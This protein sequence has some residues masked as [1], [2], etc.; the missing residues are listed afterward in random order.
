[1]AYHPFRH[2]GLKVLAIALA[3]LLWLTVAGEH[4]VE[5]TLRVPLEFR[6]TPAALEIVGEPPSTV[7]VRLRGSSTTLSRLEPGE[8]VTVLDLSGA[9]PGS[10]LFHLRAD[11]VRAPYGV[12]I[13]QVVPSTL[14]LVLEQSLTR[15][16][17]VVPATEGD[18]APGYVTGSISAEPSTVEVVGPESSVRQLASATTEPVVIQG[19]RGR[20]RDVVTVGVED[21]AV[22]LAQPQRA[23]VVVEI[24][25]APVERD[26]AGV[27]VRWRNLGTGL[28]ARVAPTLV[29]VSVRGQQD[30]LAALMPDG[31]EA[32]VDLTGLG[33]GQY[34]LQVQ[35]DPSERFGVGTITPPVV[36]VTIR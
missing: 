22:R 25:P 28:R 33:P 34:N 24:I 21:A 2:L 16:V 1:M 12:R 19:V 13:A 20:V 15:A 29:H 18:P 26:V 14:S 3:T 9:R 7:D 36:S 32:F 6:N 23:T 31:V 35:T 11:E 4:E 30:V 5:R 8:V 10:R 17:P 27:P